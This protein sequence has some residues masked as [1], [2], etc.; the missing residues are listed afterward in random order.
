MPPTR[1]YKRYTLF[2]TT[3]AILAIILAWVCFQG[4][5][6]SVLQWF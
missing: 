2:A 4:G 1:F 3:L 6:P 5:Y